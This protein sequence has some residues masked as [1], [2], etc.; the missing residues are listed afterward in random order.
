MLLGNDNPQGSRKNVV[1]SLGSE[2]KTMMLS[3]GIS[4]ER[5]ID[6]VLLLSRGLIWLF[7]SF[8]V[9]WSLYLVQSNGPTLDL[10]QWCTHVWFIL[11]LF[12]H[13][14]YSYVG[15]PPLLKFETYNLNVQTT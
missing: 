8:S 15:Y 13:C 5:Q 9:H 3:L 2:A 4:G 10:V 7:I 6:L 1:E 14:L 12:I 11:K